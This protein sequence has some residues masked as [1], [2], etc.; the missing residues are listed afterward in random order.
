[1]DL[2]AYRD[3]IVVSTKAGYGMWPGPYGDFGSRKYLLASLDQSL[4]RMGLPY[5]DIFY[6]HRPDPE[7]PLEETMG[8]LD[9]AVRSGKALYAA[10]PTTTRRH[11]EGRGYFAPAGDAVPDPPVPLLD[12][13]P[14]AGAR[15]A[16]DAA[17]GERGWHRVF[18]A[19]AGLLSERYL[20]GGIPPIPAPRGL[21]LPQA[22]GCGRASRR[23][24]ARFECDCPGPR[25]EPGAN[26]AGMGAAR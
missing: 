23:P 19:G 5:V 9:Q 13:P 8:A 22:Q 3:E 12:V 7:T 11:R 15:A 10:F 14:R 4:G 25:P 21:R 16:G 6:H 2:A 18:S 26:G 24:G 20:G 17:A 1:M